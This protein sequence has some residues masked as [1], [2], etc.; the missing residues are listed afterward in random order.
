M[1]TLPS[2]L[3]GGILAS[4]LESRNWLVCS[5]RSRDL[6]ADSGR[7]VVFF[8]GW[9]VCVVGLDF[10]ILKTCGGRSS[11]D[12]NAAKIPLKPS[13]KIRL[14][15]HVSNTHCLELSGWNSHF[16]LSI[17]S[18]MGFGTQATEKMGC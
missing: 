7:A 4:V 2:H 3:F 10:A 12:P 11:P 6:R 17:Y 14:V 8:A 13:L 15:H 1:T 18:M 16:V 9:V 5:Q